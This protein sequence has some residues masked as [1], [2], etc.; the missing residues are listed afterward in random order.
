VRGGVIY[1]CECSLDLVTRK[2][3]RC[4][5][6]LCGESMVTESE[7]MTQHSHF[8]TRTWLDGDVHIVVH[9]LLER[10]DRQ[11]CMGLHGYFDSSSGNM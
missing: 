10:G 5:Q 1:R 7:G 2:G 3:F 8:G 11:P 4:R 6:S 9:T